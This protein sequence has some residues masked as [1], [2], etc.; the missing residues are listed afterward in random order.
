MMKRIFFALL[1]FLLLAGL[2]LPLVVQAQTGLE[3]T[4][5]SASVDFPLRLNFALAAKSSANI[6]DIRLHYQIG[7]ESFAKVTDEV[8]MQFA[9]ST[10]VD[11]TYPLEMIKTGGLPPGASVTYWWTLKDQ[12]G[13]LASTDPVAVQFNDDRYAWQQITEGKVT[14][15]WYRGSSA[16][17]EELMASAQAGLANLNA[18][19]GAELEKPVRIYIYGSTKDMQGA[20][21][22]AP[23]DW[24][25]GLAF[26]RY[27]AIAIGIETNNLN[28]GDRAIVHEL[29][30][31][32][33][34]Q[35]TINPYNNL[36]VWLD[37]GLA[38]HSEGPMEASFSAALA[39]AVRN[40]KLISA[41]SLCSP[42]SA[43]TDQAILAY[44]ES[45]SLVG[46]LIST[47]GENEMLELLHTFQS[48]STFDGAFEKVYG[49]DMDG[50]NELWQKSVQAQYGALLP[51]FS[52]SLA[53]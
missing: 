11:I 48:G 34:G 10:S 12:Q 4:N 51:E 42:F 29:T 40:N 23:G 53:A 46:Y 22:Y 33:I 27:G 3:I 38:V 45:A 36:P 31:L 28:W 9:P 5:S 6:V 8:A 47:Y 37:E 19:T 2:N 30:H 21:V 35:V 43:Y 7:M 44:A 32:L 50:L 16:F 39:D 24:A 49:F 13:R 41:R 15:Y 1:A 17:A 20:L 25:G 26:V 14:L 18:D 52:M